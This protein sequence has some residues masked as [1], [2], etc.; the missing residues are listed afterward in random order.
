MHF[1]DLSIWRKLTLLTLL[2]TSCALIL[3]CVGFAFYERASF[4]ENT[5]SELSALAATLGANTAASLVFNDAKT[6]QDMLSS[7]QSEAHILAAALYEGD[8]RI[9][10]AY[11]RSDQ[12]AAG[13]LPAWHPDGAYFEGGRLVLFRAVTLHGDRAGS[14]A[15]VSDLRGF[16]EKTY[17]YV[18][19]AALV[20]LFS[21]GA[22]YLIS[23]RLLRL[24]T[25]PI[26][27]LASIA[28]RVA[29]EKNYGLRVAAESGDEIGRLVH[30]FNQM[31][32]AIQQRDDALHSANDELEDRV[33]ART[34]ELVRAKEVAE[35]ASQAKSEF[36]ANM[37]HEIRTPLNGVIGMTDLALDTRLDSEQREYLETVKSSADSLLTVINDVL[38]F[39]KIEAGRMDLENVEF[40]LR[41]VLEL[42]LKGLALRADEKGLELLCEIAPQVPDS[43]VAD[44]T[45]LR[46][47]IIN[48]VG[49]AIKFTHEG[50]VAVN[51]TEESHDG[52]ERV[53][54]FAVSDTGIGIPEDKQNLIFDPFAQADTSTTRKY[55]GTG[56]GL[57]ISARLIAMMGGRIWLNSQ[58]GRGSQFHF[59]LKVTSTERPVE[60]GT[61]AP[62]ELL[63]GAR[64]L[65][66]DDNSTNRRILQGMLKRW[67]MTANT[68]PGGAEALAEL[69]AARQAGEPYR[70]VITDMHM[71]GM[72]GFA[73]TERIRQSPDFGT[74]TI[75]MLTS[76]GHRGDAERC[77]QL[78]IAAYLLKPIRQSELREAIARVLG[79]SHQK[80]PI[81]LITRYSLHDAREPDQIL[82]ILVVEDN[83]VNQRLATRLLEKRGH[84][85][86]IAANGREALEMLEKETFEIVLMDIQMPEMDG[87]EATMIVRR[88]EKATGKHQ[89]IIALTAHAMKGDEERCLSAGMDGYLTK[90]I[91][92][93]ELDEFLERFMAAR[94]PAPVA[95]PAK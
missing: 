38:D 63:R 41:D 86:A 74:A 36:L 88:N 78:G 4:R 65:V 42:T 52:K 55:G 40:N 82:R 13:S 47:V 39:S 64:V 22:T 18:Q 79:A 17:E 33:K 71:P 70:L 77:K 89:H 75:M 85:V 21:V 58:P 11:R 84:R 56:L 24:V 73:L 15:I 81:A 29:E 7:L 93:A 59:T 35:V 57:T 16:R 3:A 49:N 19:I 2:A 9:F 46:Q 76:A 62:A 14:I 20:L 95:Q 53:L 67:E 28:G 26:R 23:L 6:A 25:D 32:E 37:S 91:R 34:V 54:H 66:V 43:V 72:D 61:A 1:R 80:G 27:E 60:P 92:P 48:L 10:A 68:V 50:E 12:S 44:P 69:A 90:P 83:L 45:R 8:G 30:G 31:L 51:V 5:T 87:L 94:Q